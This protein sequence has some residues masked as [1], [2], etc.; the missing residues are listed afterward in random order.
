M[1]RQTK[2]VDVFGWGLA[3]LL[4]LAAVVL[5]TGCVPVRPVTPTPQPPIVVTEPT[6]ATFAVTVV[7][8]DQRTGRPV[9]ANIAGDGWQARSNKAGF[10]RRDGLQ[11]TGWQLCASAEQ[12]ITACQTVAEPKTHV[13]VFNLSGT[14]PP[15]PTPRVIQGQFVIETRNPFASMPDYPNA[16]PDRFF[17]AEIDVLW[18][19]DKAEAERILT[20]YV[21]KGGT[22]LLTGPVFANG[23]GRHYPDTRWLGRAAEYAEFL[24]WVYRHG[25][26]VTLVVMTDTGPYYD[27]RAG[28]FDH[29]AIERDWTPF[30]RE[31]RTLV[32][33]PKRVVSQWE[34]YQDTDESGWLFDWMRREFPTEE[35][36]WHNPPNHLGPGLSTKDEAEAARHA[37][38]HG[39]QA[40]AYQADPYGGGDGRNA[41]EQMKYDLWD[42]VRRSH[43]YAGWPQGFKVYFAEGTAH[44]MYWNGGTQALAS[45]W[46]RG[47]MSVAGVSE[48]WDG[49]P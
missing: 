33:F 34:Q 31:L 43:G 47:A 3:L 10:L 2:L 41:F 12:Y 4:V 1:N 28:T 13:F 22:H 23:Y 26:F 16:R 48:T 29:A 19:R 27:D 21:A 44:P 7:V 20:E 45:Q 15:V 30:Y 14:A 11:A 46:G 32:P 39:I 40:W 9:Q 24:K 35:R 6:P 37:M 17:L 42:L 25:V 18:E 8:T 38:A 5:L 36:V 49:L